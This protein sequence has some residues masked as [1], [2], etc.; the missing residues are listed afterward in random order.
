MPVSIAANF[1][2]SPCRHAEVIAVL[3]RHHV[4]ASEECFLV[5]HGLAARHRHSTRNK[6]CLMCIHVYHLP[7]SPTNEQQITRGGDEVSIPKFLHAVIKLELEAEPW[8]RPHTSIKYESN[9]TFSSYKLPEEA[10]SDK[11][12]GCPSDRE[13]DQRTSRSRHLIHQYAL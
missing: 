13:S 4:Q 8:L 3:Q 10:H 12:L 11:C 6:T 9:R 7:D 2:R 5:H 1:D